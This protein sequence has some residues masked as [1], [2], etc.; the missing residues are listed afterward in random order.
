MSRRRKPAANDPPK[1]RGFERATDPDP[2]S[3]RVRSVAAPKARVVDLTRVV[4]ARRRIASGW[5]DRADVRESLVEA[6]L[7]EIRGR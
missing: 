2:G 4:E 1:R 5:Y 6:V 3:A 7:Q